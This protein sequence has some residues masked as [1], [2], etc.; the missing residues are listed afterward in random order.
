AG[1]ADSN[2]LG[3]TSSSTG[4]P[5]PTGEN[6]FLLAIDSPSTE[7]V[8]L[9]TVKGWRFHVDFVTPANSTLGMGANHTPDALMTVS[10]FVDAFS[11][12]AGFTLVPQQGTT[13]KLDTLVD[14]IMT[15]LVYQNRS[16]T[17]SLR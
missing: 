4:S 14:K 10:A 6:E 1:L 8:T 12:T 2:R 11:T 3:A 16:G 7:N 9:T 15:P 17:E 13:Q 5:P